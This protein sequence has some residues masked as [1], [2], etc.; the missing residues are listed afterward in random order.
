MRIFVDTNVIL[1][2]FLGREKFAVAD[3]LFKMLKFQGHE[4]LMSVGAFYTMIFLVD[5]YLKK[6]LG[7]VGP[8]RILLL[9]SIM[10]D[11]L[12][13]LQVAEHDNASL[14]RGIDN[15]QFKDL[16]DGCQ[17]E[18]AMKSGCSMLLTFNISDYPLDEKAS[19]K[20]LTPQDYIAL[21]ISNSKE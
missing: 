18:L 10:S 9:R 16:E 15:V 20:V 13:I 3:R 19:L 8:D 7:I 6:E 14:L 5:K 1:E 12:K 17:Y 2:K 4:M 11:T 21:C